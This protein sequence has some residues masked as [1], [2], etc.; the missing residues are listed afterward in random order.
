MSTGC[1]PEPRRNF[2]T[3]VGRLASTVAL[4]GCAAT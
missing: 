2:L 4:V 1:D 3:D